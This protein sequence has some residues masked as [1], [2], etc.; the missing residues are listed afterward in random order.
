MIFNMFISDLAEGT[1]CS[2]SSFT[3]QK[4]RSDPNTRGMWWHSECLEEVEEWAAVLCSSKG[5]AKSCACGGI[6]SYK[7]TSCLESKQPES[8][9]AEEDLNSNK[10]SSSQEDALAKATSTWA[11]PEQHCQHCGSGD[12]SSHARFSK[13]SAVFLKSFEIIFWR[14]DLFHLWYLKK[15]ILVLINP[16]PSPRFISHYILEHRKP[17]FVTWKHGRNQCY[18]FIIEMLKQSREADM[19]RPRVQ[20]SIVFPLHCARLKMHTACSSSHCFP[21]CNIVQN[22]FSVQ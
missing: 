6:T 11:A 18:S 4:T 9:F 7:R 16:Y 15:K 21:E 12:P 5:G 22:A 19:D 13:I 1:E 2:S 10:L 8:S 20:Q 3:Q 14:K 17:W